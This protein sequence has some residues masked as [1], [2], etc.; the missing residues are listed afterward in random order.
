MF[1]T[2]HFVIAS[3]VAMF[4]IGAAFAGP[5]GTPGKNFNISWDEFKGR[6]ANPDSFDNQ[7][8][9]R[10]ITIQCTNTEHEYVADAPGAVDLAANRHVST[11]VLSDKFTVSAM[12]K[13]YPIATKPGSCQPMCSGLRATSTTIALR[14]S[15]QPRAITP[16]PLTSVTPAFA[17]T[18]A[19]A[20]AQSRSKLRFTQ[21]RGNGMEPSPFFYSKNQ[22]IY[23]L[24]ERDH[25]EHF[26]DPSPVSIGSRHQFVWQGHGH[27][28]RRGA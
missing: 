26:P 16:R 13:D 10:A 9:P 23:L 21:K 7:R 20:K 22:P 14:H 19:A 15:T 28:T 12:E 2:H 24:R 25:V 4:S 18:L 6:C 17:S 1:K 27:S 5:T 11:A 3:L 8:E